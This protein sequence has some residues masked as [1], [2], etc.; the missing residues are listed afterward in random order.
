MLLFKEWTEAAQKWSNLTEFP[1]YQV[2]DHGLVR[3]KNGDLLKLHF[4]TRQAGFYVRLGK[5]TRLVHKLVLLAFIGPSKARIIHNNGNKSDNRLS[6]LCYGEQGHKS[7]GKRCRKNHLL[8]GVNVERLG[9]SRIC[10]ACR[11]G[12]PPVRELP[13]FI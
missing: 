4:A 7:V 3:N 5:T 12:E 8:V 10:V 1:G 11:N 13:E 9:S 2:S 6:N